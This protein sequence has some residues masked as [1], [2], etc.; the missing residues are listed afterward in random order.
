MSWGYTFY[1]PKQL[2]LTHQMLSEETVGTFDDPTLFN[3]KLAIYPCDKQAF[4]HV[5]EGMP[6]FEKLPAR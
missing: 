4:H 2:P 1:P 5:P 6:A 3:P